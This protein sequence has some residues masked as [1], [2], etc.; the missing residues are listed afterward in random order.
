MSSKKRNSSTELLDFP[1]DSFLETLIASFPSEWQGFFGALNAS[2]PNPVQNA[3]FWLNQKQTSSKDSKIPPNFSI[4]F[5]HLT[6]DFP[7]VVK[8]NLYFKPKLTLLPLHLQRN[9]F[10]FLLSKSASIPLDLLKVLVTKLDEFK[11]N[12]EG[13]SSTLGKLLKVKIKQLEREADSSLCEE[14]AMF[15]VNVMTDQSKER[16]LGLCEE[17]NNRHP[18][19]D[20]EYPSEAKWISLDDE[21]EEKV[22]EKQDTNPGM[23][24][25]MPMDNGEGISDLKLVE[26][27]DEKMEVDVTQ[28]FERDILNQKTS[29]N[30]I[31]KALSPSKKAKIEDE[32]EEMKRSHPAPTKFEVA[33]EQPV[34]TNE[35]KAKIAP[36][37]NLI[38]ALESSEA[39]KATTC[40]DALN[41]FCELSHF[42]IENISNIVKLEDLSDQTIASL[43]QN[44]ASLESEPSYMHACAFASHFILLRL[45]K[46]EQM[47]SRVITATVLS[48]SKKYPKAVCEGLFIRLLTDLS[49]SSLQAD[50]ISKAL[51]DMPNQDA[52]KYLLESLLKAQ[53]SSEQKGS[54]NEDTVL[55][56][57]TIIDSK[58][59]LD[60]SLFKGY[61]SALQENSV[62]MVKSLKFAKLLLATIN[63]YS[64]Q[65]VYHR[66][67]IEAILQSNGTFLKKAGLVALKKTLAKVQS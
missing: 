14:R 46:L 3:C 13:W 40:I 21:T 4:L 56:L 42:E 23:I 29:E 50:I 8:D 9:L 10:S 37:D 32:A 35:F 51:K 24:I 16:F 1:S 44:F 64:T 57:Q 25:S 45:Q 30:E 2:S 43:C 15:Y 39:V 6:Q 55:V 22:N 67:V 47:A 33:P 65:I 34:I 12:L 66:E 20:K 61:I 53:H 59:V 48:F 38:Q 18:C 49:F 54:W 41:I 60:D 27:W 63:N 11:D 7:V 52:S 28:N 17:I 5:E 19:N 36:L 26:I 31:T 58:P 62:A